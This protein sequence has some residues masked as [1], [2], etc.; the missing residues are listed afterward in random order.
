MRHRG[1]NL[2]QGL[3]PTK[4]L[5]QCEYLRPLGYSD[6]RV[7]PTLHDEGDHSTSVLHLPFRNFVLWM[8]RMKGINK[9]FNFRMFFEKLDDRQSVFRMTVHAD[10]KGLDTA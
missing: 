7:A 8:R 10:G 4:G 6:R 1:R 5:G 2:D 9:F 3:N